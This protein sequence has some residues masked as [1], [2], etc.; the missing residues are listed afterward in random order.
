MI[1]GLGRIGSGKTSGPIRRDEITGSEDQRM[2]GYSIKP[3]P[4]ST[5][6]ETRAT[7]VALEELSRREEELA[8]GIETVLAN[9]VHDPQNFA[10]LMAHRA[11]VTD[12]RLVLTARCVAMLEERVRRLESRLDDASRDIAGH[13]SVL[14]LLCEVIKELDDPYGM[15]TSLDDRIAR[16]AWNPPPGEREE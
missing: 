12:R 2:S 5:G 6:E 10:R 15:G 1:P 9:E 3:R 16:E 13:E 11:A 14:R 4:S 7:L 8:R